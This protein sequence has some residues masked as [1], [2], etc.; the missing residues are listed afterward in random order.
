MMVVIKKE[1]M[2]H[3]GKIAQVEAIIQL[4]EEVR[5]VKVFCMM[6][7]LPQIIWMML[8]KKVTQMLG[9]LQKI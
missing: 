7:E 5:L 9:I 2:K 1:D 6:V 4:E 8:M 3:L